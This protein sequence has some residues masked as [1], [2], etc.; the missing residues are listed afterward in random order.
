VTTCKGRD[1]AHEFPNSTGRIEL[2]KLL[3]KILAP[4]KHEYFLKEFFFGDGGIL[5]KFL[6]RP[7]QSVIGH[8][9][10]Q[11]ATA[12]F[13][14]NELKN[15]IDAFFKEDAAVMKELVGLVE[16]FG[17]IGDDLFHIN[18]GSRGVSGNG[19]SFT[20][21]SFHGVSWY[22]RGRR[23]ESNLGVKK[24]LKLPALAGGQEQI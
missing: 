5:D 19:R 2:V 12:E 8:E 18:H 21:G 9:A 15:D 1:A 24:K 7:P 10:I 3:L 4:V 6:E 16:E 11:P 13:G 22:I 23:P 17:V 20:S 14:A